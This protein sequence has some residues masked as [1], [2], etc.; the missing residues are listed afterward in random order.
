MHSQTIRSLGLYTTLLALVSGCYARLAGKAA[1]GL[2]R[3]E[4]QR[5]PLFIVFL[6]D[7]WEEWLI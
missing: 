4:K 3:G 5:S 2:I 7:I 6:L 1:E